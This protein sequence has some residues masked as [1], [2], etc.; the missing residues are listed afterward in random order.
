VSLCWAFLVCFRVE[1]NFIFTDNVNNIKKSKT[2]TIQNYL[3]IFY[4]HWVTLLC[5]RGDHPYKYCNL[6]WEIIHT[7]LSCDKFFFDIRILINRLVSSNSSYIYQSTLYLI[8]QYVI[9]F[10]SDLWQIGG[11]LHVLCS[12]HQ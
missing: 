3:N 7:L 6:Q 2:T 5:T 8:Q 4:I 1:I 9:K 11:F 12:L 10:V